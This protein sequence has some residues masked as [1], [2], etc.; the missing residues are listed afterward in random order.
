MPRI[1]LYISHSNIFQAA[2]CVDGTKPEN[3]LVE[4][5]TTEISDGPRGAKTTYVEEL[6]WHEE[7]NPRTIA[8]D[9]ALGKVKTPFDVGIMGWQQRLPL[10]YEYFPTGS[11]ATLAGNYSI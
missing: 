5:A 9:I 2:H 7:Y 1:F 11:P 8:N 4:Y 3:H 10:R 6:H